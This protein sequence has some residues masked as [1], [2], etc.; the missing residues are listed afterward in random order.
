MLFGIV[1]SLQFISRQNGTTIDMFTAIPRIVFHRRQ[2]NLVERAGA[3]TT[4][5]TW[6]G[7][8]ALLPTVHDWQCELAN[9]RY[10]I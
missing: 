4:K 3:L 7:M 8:L 5:L 1:L 9:V 10:F 2:P 6:A